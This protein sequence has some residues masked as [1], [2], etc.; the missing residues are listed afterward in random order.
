MAWEVRVRW[1]GEGSGDSGG[2]L[3]E[4]DGRRRLSRRR[5]K[6]QRWPKRERKACAGKGSAA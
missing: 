5:M 3:G 4:V 6:L 2:D 1:S